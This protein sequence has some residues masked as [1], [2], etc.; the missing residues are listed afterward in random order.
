M[1]SHDEEHFNQY[2][3]HNR[4]K[5]EILGKY[6]EAYSTALR[7][8]AAAFHYIDGFAGSGFYEEKYQ[9][10]PLIA[11]SILAKQDRPFSVSFIEKRPSFFKQLEIAVTNHPVVKNSSTRLFDAPFLRRG[12]FQDHVEEILARPIYSRH[13]ACATFAF[14]DPCGLRGVRMRDLSKVL[15]KRYGECLLFWNYD[16]INRWL[17]AVYKKRVSN[18][19]LV[20][21]F[22]D[23]AKVHEALQY[24][25]SCGFSAEKEQ[26]LLALFIDALREYGKP[27]VLPFRVE[28]RGVERTSHYLIHVSGHWLAFKIMKEVMGTAATAANPGALAYVSAADTAEMFEPVEEHARSEILTTLERGPQPASLFYEKWIV[29]PRDFLREQDYRRLLLQLEDADQIEILDPTGTVPAPRDQRRKTAGGKPTLSK[30]HI[31]RRKR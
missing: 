24:Y 23:E 19:G 25:H 22:G 17:G 12:A 11:L 18:D 20:A 13:P 4:V 16:G 9:G 31:I 26:R 5:H 29:R 7:D 8:R 3:A 10:S 27:Y 15:E 21:L 14:V 2:N 28:A 6:L 1:P 30:N